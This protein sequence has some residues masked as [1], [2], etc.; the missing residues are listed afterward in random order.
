MDPNTKNFQLSIPSQLNLN[1]NR[2]N[3][4]QQ[5]ITLNIL[6]SQLFHG[7]NRSLFPLYTAK[8]TEPAP[9]KTPSIFRATLTLTINYRKVAV[10]PRTI[11]HKYFRAVSDQVVLA[12]IR[13][14]D[15][16]VIYCRIRRLRIESGRIL[17]DHKSRRRLLYAGK[18]EKRRLRYALKASR[19]LLFE[20]K[21][22]G[23]CFKSAAIVL[24]I[25]FFIFYLKR[26]I[27]LMDW[28]FCCI[29]L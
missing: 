25:S 5:P 2:L 24:P 7:I 10:N 29:G 6:D 12:I 14:T 21:S 20:R 9:Q 19:L 8:L 4:L 16:L 15:D 28:K 11:S 17:N 27:F 3:D 22:V 26:E 13:R 1:P 18:F 23:V